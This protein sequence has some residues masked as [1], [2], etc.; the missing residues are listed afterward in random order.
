MSGIV[1]TYEPEINKIVDSAVKAAVDSAVKVAVDSTIKSTKDSMKLEMKKEN[2]KSILRAI[3]S[4]R[5][6]NF[7]RSLIKELLMKTYELSAQEAEHYLLS[8]E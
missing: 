7:D 4:Y 2:E 3:E 5:D 1:R 8:K 6:L